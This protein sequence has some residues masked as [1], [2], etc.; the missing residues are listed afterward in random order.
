MNR[1]DALLDAAIDYVADRGLAN[2]SLRPLATALGTSGRLLIFHFGSK[3]NL[4]I[5]LLTEVQCRF[6]RS[7]AAFPRTRRNSKSTL[8]Q[9][10]WK[11]LT[12]P[13]NLKLLRILYEAQFIAIRQPDRLAGYFAKTSRDWATVIRSRLPDALRTPE[14]VLLCSAVFDGLLIDVLTSGKKAR[15]GRSIDRFAALLRQAAGDSA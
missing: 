5:E 4:L 12:A 11:H 3:E 10:Y 9:R 8:F 1:H 13:E 7:L 14:F 2:L 6:Q 15:A